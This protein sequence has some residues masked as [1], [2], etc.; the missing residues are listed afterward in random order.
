MPDDN[1]AQGG[2][3]TIVEGGA[4]V[5][6]SFTV[7]A[8]DGLGSLT[9]GGTV[10]TPAQLASL[11]T[12]PVAI[13]TG[14]GTLTLTGF[15]PA[16]GTVTYTYSA[17]A[18]TNP[19]DV[20]DSIPVVVT[21]RAGNSATDSLDILI[22]D[23]A[24]VARA[25]V[26]SIVEDTAAPATG[27]VITTGAGADTLAADAAQVATVTF[28]ATPGTVGSPLAGAHGSL[29][30]NPDGSYSYTLNNA[31]PAV[32]ALNAGE[33]LTEVF[34]Y[35]LRDADGDES[36]TT[37]TIT[38]NGATDGP[39]VIRVPDDNAAQAGDNTIVEGGAPITGSFT[40]SAPD[41]LG[42]LTVGGTVL[43]PAQLANL[44][45]LP[46]AINTGEG[47]LTLTGF[48]PATGR[49]SYSY[50][51]PAQTSPA[52]VLDSIPVVVTDRAGNSATDSLDIL[53]TD[54]APAARP[55]LNSVG[56]DAVAPAT[57][58]VITAA[59]GADTLGAD[60]AQVA[61]VS[62]N[63][64][65]GAVGAPVAGAHGTLTLNP[66]GSYSYL[67]NTADP[68][69]QGLR[70]AQSLTEVFTYVLRD[71]DGDES[72]TTLTITINGS[73]DAPVVLPEAGR[74]PEDQPLNGNVLANDTDVDGPSLAVTGINVPGLGSFAP[75]ATITFPTEG[76]LVIR[77]DGSFTFTP[78]PNYNGPVPVVT[79]TVSD[80]TS[81]RDATL[82]L[83]VEPVNDAP[84]G[85]NKT[86]LATE[87]TPVTVTTADFGFTDPDTGDTLAAVRIDTLPLATDGRLLLNGV[88]V[89]PGQVISRADLDAGQLRFEPAPNRAG[90]SLGAFNFS[91]QDSGTPALFDPSPN[92]INFTIAQVN[93]PPVANDD[94]ASTPINQPVVINVKAN[95]TDPDNAPAQLTVSNPVV[96]PA[97]GTAVVNPDGTITFTPA[98]NI[99][100]PVTI[101]YTLTDPSGASDIAVIT[102]NVGT[103][104]PPAGTDA[105]RTIDED[106]PYT[107]AASDFGFTDADL[108]Q[109]L[110]SVRIDSVAT[111]GRLQLN[112]VN[113]VAGQVVPVASINAG[114]LKF[115]PDL[116]ENGN[117]YA[118]FTF[119][120]Q[121]SAGS[122]D[123]LPNTFL[124][125]VTPVNDNPVARADVGSTT[126][127]LVLNVS[128][129][130]GV[131]TS[132]AVAAGRD[133]DVDLDTLTVSA[134]SFGANPGAVGSVLA[135]ANGSL[136]LAADG[137]YRYVPAA[138]T[139]ALDD[140]ESVQDVFTYTV[141]DGNGGTAT[142]TLTITVTGTNDAPQLT[143][144]T[145]TT[146]ED[147]A[148]SDNVLA[149]DTDAD[150]EALTVTSFT[151]AGVPGTFTPGQN[152][153]IPGVGTLVIQPNG[154]YTFTPA[155]NFT[156]PAPLVTY[157]ATDGT[158]PV[159][160]TLT[161][162][163]TPV[164]D[165][166]VANDDS[167]TTPI[168]RPVTID[169][170]ANDSDPDNTPAQLTVSNPV[171]NPAQGTAVVNPD[172]TI[173]FTPANNVTGPV[174]ITYTLTD[175]NGL[176]DT[177]TITVNVGANTPP[178]G[179]DVVRTIAEDTSYTVQ[180][181]DLGFTDADV[182]QTLAAVR[183]DTLPGNGTLT[184]NGVAVTA[185]QVISVAAITA[186]Q[187]RMAPDTNENGNNYAS[188][189][190]SVQDNAGAFDT[191]PNTFTLN[192]TPVNDLPVALADVGST[193]EQTLL[194]VS[195]ANG[196]ITSTAVPAGRD[197]DLDGDTLTVSAVS[198]GANAG[199]VGLPLAGA[200]GSLVLNADGSYTFTPA[201]STDALD[202]GESVVDLF[203]YTVS[204]GN[205]GLATTTLTITVTGTNDAPT[206]VA[207]VG[208]APEDTPISGNVLAN[209]S[210]VDVEPLSVASFSVAG[211]PGSFAAGTTATIPGVGTLLI[212]TD[213]NYLFTPAANFNGAVP[214]ATYLAS[215]G[216]AS[217]PGTLTLNITPVN[218][219]P[220][221][222]DKTITTAEDTPVTLSAADFGFAD[223]D[224]GDTL[225][226]VRI[227]S[228]P[229]TGSLTLNGS[230]IAAGAVVTLADINAGL[231]RYA[232]PA[233]AN[234]APLAGFD[235]SVRDS[236][237]PANLFDLAPNRISFNVTPVNDA[238]S[239]ADK[240]LSGTEDTPVTITAADFGFTDPDVGDTLA[241]VRIDVLPATGTLAL[242]GTPVTA[243][244]VVSLADITAGLLRYTPVLNANGT[245]ASFDFSVRDSGSP[246][247]FDVAPNRISIN[248]AAVNDPPVAN[249]DVAFTPINQAVTV[250]VKANDTDPDNAPAQLTVS[251]PVVNPALGTAVVNPDGTISFTPATNVSGPVTITYTLTD[252]D[253]QSDTATITVNVGGNTPPTGAD[254][255]RTIAEDGSYT[256]LAS[257]LGFA[258][259]DAGQTLSAV[260]I[261]SLPGNGTLQLNGVNVVL[262]Q[263]VPVAAINAGQL[264]IAPDANE[265][266]NN[267]S[268]FTFSVQDNAGG[269]DTVPNTFTLNVTP[270]NDAPSGADKTVSTAED[271][272]YTVS[273]ADFGF[274]DPDVGDTLAVV[275]IDS[276]PVTGTLQ[277]NGANLAVGQTVTVAEVNAG[278]LR[279]VP[280]ANS[281][282]TPLANFTFSV[283][284]PGGLFDVAPNQLNITV[285]PVN[286]NPVANPDQ[287]S[288]TEN[289]VL[290]V[291]V[292]NGVI[293]SGLAPA[294][295]D[296]DVDG[297]SLSVSA[298]SFGATP[299]AIGTPLVAANGSLT[300]N[301]DG[302]YSYAPNAA[303]NALDA[304]ESVQDVFTYTVSDGK[305][306]TAQTTL[307]ITV[308]GTNDAPTVV[309]DTN[310]GPEDNPLAGNVLANDVD[311]DVEPLSV[312]SFSVTGV[313]GTF[314]AGSTATIPGVGTLLIQANGDYTF[315]PVANFNG[316]VPQVSYVATDGTANS[317][318]TLSL[319]IDPVNDAPAGTNKLLTTAE[320][321]PITITAADFGFSDPDLGDTLAAV[322]IDTLP[323][324]GTLTLNGVAIPAGTL[325]SVADINAGRLS[326]APGANLN[327][328]SLAGFNFS[329]Q[330]SGSPALFDPVPNRL[331]FSVTPVNDPPVAN[332]D[333]ATTPIN[334]AVT[335]NVKAN[336]SDPDNTASQLSV[337]NPVV[338]PAQGSAVVNPDGTITFT[339]ANNFTGA[340]TITYTL[341]DPAGLTD[342]AV[343]TVTVG[344]N[345]PP[346]G[347]DT[348]RTILEDGSYTLLSGDFGF[349]DADAGQ[350]LTAVRIDTLPGNGTLTLN[351]VAVTAGQVIPVAAITAGQL[352]MAP[353][354]NENGNNYASFGFSVQDNA[355]AF[356][357]APNTFTLNVTPVNDP[358]TGADKTLTTAEDTP[359][360]VTAADFGFSDVDAGDT[361]SA[362]RID[363]LPASGSLT[364]NGAPVTAGT[365]VTVADINAGLLRYVP[366]ANANGAPLATFDFSVQD[367]TLLFDA[368]PNRITLNVTPVND[369][370]SGVDKVL[371]GTED[372]PVTITA[373]DF[374]FTD[375]DVGDTLAAVR[376]DVLPATGTLA[377]NG[378]PVTAGT[379]V[380]LADI[381][382]GL[383]RY[384]PVLNANGAVASFDFSV[385]DSGSP[386]L[387]DVAPNRI[388]ISLAA[389]NDPP[390]ANDD[391]ATTPINQPVTVNVKAND[392][393]PDN[394]P[395]QLT[396]SNPVVNP[397]QGTAVVNPDGTITFTPAANVTG[398]V[399]ITYT[400]T[401]PSGA[402]DTATVTVNVGA[403]TPPTGADVT[404]TIAEDGS[405]TVLAS[406]LG[407]A[408]ADAG[409]T[410]SAV[411]IDSLPAKGTLQ[412]NGVNVVLGQTISV[413][414]I[415]AGQLRIAP[416]ANDNGNAYSN[417]TFSVQDNAGAFDTAPNTFT[418][419]VTP[420]NDA[421]S[422]A[423]KTVSTAED[424]PYT[425]SAADFGFTDPDVGDTLA[426]VRIDSLP[427]TGTL[428]LNGA[429]L[430][431][432]QTV[433]VAEVNAGLL[434]YVPPANSFGTPLAN[435]TFSVR[436]PG[437]L[438]DVAPNQLNITVT[439]VNDNPV[440]NPDQGSTTE[441]AV[442]TV[443]VANGV[444]TSGLAPAG[445]DTDVDGDSLSVS[446]VSFGATPGAVGSALAGT[447]GS[448]V[449]NANGSYTY[450][451]NAAANGLDTGESVQD[452]F[453][454][455]V[456]DG[457]GGT[458]QTSLTITVNGANDAPVLVADANRG[459]ED[460]P[461]SGNVL[462]NDTDPDVEPL[463]V[464]SFSIAGVA[465][466]F[467]AGTTAT[468]PSV[469]TLVINANG[470][471]TFTPLAN[472]NGT[473][474]LVTYVA[475]DGTANS[476][477]TLSL[478]IDPVNDA[479][480]GTSKTITSPEDTQYTLTAGDF[481]F[482]DPDIGDTMSAVRIDT[483]PASGQLTLNGVPVTAGTVVTIADINAGLL[484]YTPGANLNGES[485]VNFDF[486]V[487]DSGSPLLFDP[488]P[489]KLTFS[490]TPVNDAPVAGNDTAVATEDIALVLTPATLLVN[491]TDPDN[492]PLT[493]V[494]VQ[495][496]VNGSVALVGGQRGVHP[497]HELQRPGVLH[498]YG[499]RRRRADLHRHGEP[500]RQRGGRPA[501]A[502][503]GHP[504]G[505]ARGAEQLGGGGQR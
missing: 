72:T 68:A 174:T 152:A 381:N 360:T 305:G 432:G 482:S 279:Y 198:F 288:T 151:V 29:T 69:V 63:G 202:S 238:P 253:G 300:L 119:S 43:T 364:L 471:Y 197:T 323:A 257:D 44:G 290:T 32:Q 36:T 201:A 232:A 461:L 322:R 414:A 467:T 246:T 261:D 160:S 40:V 214:V 122:F 286:D 6:G 121:D 51:A 78:A 462:T 296:T 437:G 188:F 282:G 39:P 35:V 325:V 111:N 295:A 421:P 260:R 26:N 67:L 495:G 143:A 370:P 127:D 386:A 340:A 497:G 303:A 131:I 254:V 191:A 104:N 23:T 477:T 186:G 485:L 223:V 289:A 83:S 454:Y 10:L 373:A 400:L 148:V 118:T 158:A 368:A 137:S 220:T 76:T 302:S 332:D 243:G 189:G 176:S 397:A 86:L 380:S 316:T 164:N 263:I 388:S 219:A 251:N 98:A 155:L 190:F 434:R 11:G 54:T 427:V 157:T 179:A 88:P 285:T 64:T 17:P 231:L 292:A 403:N 28:G 287:G 476:S 15:D 496:A 142:S 468:I 102:V 470:S 116:N 362:V 488:T 269:F 356:D 109:T 97:L 344:A 12:T 75:G 291:P 275:R 212:Q 469:G 2:D 106:T 415:N 389:V 502:H 382:A 200:H 96:N 236:G 459:P 56:E 500:H 52:D 475:T 426:V 276:L 14:E 225:S 135:G 94:I 193:T 479:P 13:N 245:V 167:T 34:T 330:D 22:T 498:L 405:Y 60:A 84:A 447:W 419:N 237:T 87:D 384:T 161:I 138:S 21:D 210:D 320:D 16:T 478:V 207:D 59:P 490:I 136:V 124:F 453:T 42:S 297:D 348:A 448:L 169:V 249:D 19:A 398:P 456:S 396:V 304:G 420:V 328:E 401:D 128:A 166:P 239:G 375:P 271:T 178:N 255:T 114:L 410:L 77:A 494:S 278:L 92:R 74:T 5:T 91:V 318:S 312:A 347:A 298:V 411:R 358:P 337:S 203:S 107:V 307:T 306:G 147:T 281:F 377:L 144:D 4:P 465:G 125:N 338:N 120:V 473:L 372:T 272:P 80:G 445:A 283:R 112:G 187:L 233:N 20:L 218:D 393:D 460:N 481:G 499:A 66:D 267:Y 215:D 70:D 425:V 204:D 327:G 216:T 423:D 351:G 185:G 504:R 27:N 336:D 217:V 177:A 65:P 324:T 442:L 404:R 277:L 101:T 274:T 226:A 331:S 165:P 484:R 376:I 383:L 3:N 366:V 103:N 38:I 444:I 168:N 8:P 435:F 359:I 110:A 436:D 439:P 310:R 159:S 407:F 455:T 424:T 387:F 483:L 308:T 31:D 156:G 341:T 345:T 146:A 117:N 441:N 172:G 140:G 33:N 374:G 105:A 123:A 242:N 487:R 195:A 438:F 284:D 264:R 365:V 209:D 79:Y 182:G 222:A 418:L 450:T 458:A 492:N 221:G 262:G 18:Q 354:A 268:N 363:V 180:T 315:T 489:N 162:N 378:T 293:T 24:P 228:L 132:T 505:G 466:S 349:A 265:N 335:V 463:T 153:A 248:L 417:F 211:V 90:E 85:A 446:A 126:E 391:S 95:D 108:G 99:T 339:P 409:Q 175:P 49:V 334:Q 82:T 433:T 385:R 443:P 252:P 402:S 244:T 399:T 355:G 149:N 493:I 139:N 309:A 145:K 390:V 311:P 273:A 134:V 449:L 501:H 163:V 229:A 241:A 62:F 57:G 429:N 115:V 472:F 7:S 45:A 199:T 412:L 480:A 452:V 224:V 141:S 30:L 208:S 313:P 227:D 130:N 259:A 342:T 394:T 50:I 369:A 440:A 61:G 113:V 37:L 317:S 240:V 173:T 258:D 81:P 343:I 266:G 333:S 451:P 247:L 230:A 48:D 206:V 352:R 53:I 457:Q 9:V 431:V 183:I 100:G 47:T 503:R 491:D 150:V 58:N 41:G 408:D 270:V 194:T 428:Q 474:P 321:T 395:A 430:A 192:V 73:N 346:T 416:A 184:L 235:F 256:V 129:A 89:T 181:A 133:F 353:D 329:V 350:T 93:D 367:S 464:A 213:G 171:V 46:V 234:G 379:V 301:A 294:G 250:N 196:V 170:K 154:D 1:G 25:D 280:P 326:Y 71:A 413:A 299:G 205:G 371:S 314:T 406:D 422:G 55:D 361:L 319:V 486:S 392:T 357:A